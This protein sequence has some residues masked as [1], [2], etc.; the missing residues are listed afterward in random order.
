MKI[1]SRSVKITASRIETPKELAN[2]SDIVLTVEGT[3][4]KEE[5]LDLQDGTVDVVYHVK[6]VIVE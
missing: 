6:G 5:Y 3:V 1:N 2:G 4:V